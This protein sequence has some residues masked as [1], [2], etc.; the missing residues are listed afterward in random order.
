MVVKAD[1]MTF[2]ETV[3][4]TSAVLVG[5]IGAVFGSRI[6]NLI[7]LTAR[8]ERIRVEGAILKEHERLKGPRLEREF[9]PLR[10]TYQA[11]SGGTLTVAHVSGSINSLQRHLQGGSPPE[12]RAAILEDIATLLR[13][14]WWVE[15]FTSS[16]VR[17]WYAGTFGALFFMTAVM[18]YSLWKLSE[19]NAFFWVFALGLLALVTSITLL[20]LEAR[21]QARLESINRIA[22][23][24]GVY[25][26]QLRTYGRGN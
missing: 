16:R 11:F 18:A 1:E 26:E 24:T 8:E 13:I 20:L 21:R 25:L 19:G 6:V 5:L 10:A 2:F 14:R 17:R 7:D 22:E 12:V 9:E 3:A 23:T 4:A 15:G